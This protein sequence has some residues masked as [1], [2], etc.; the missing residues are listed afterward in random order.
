MFTSISWRYFTHLL[1][2]GVLTAILVSACKTTN[3]TSLTSYKQPVEDCRTVQHIMGSTCIPRNPQRVVTLDGLENTLALGI[4]PIA[5]TFVP[6]FPQ[7]KYLKGK[8]DQL[9]SVGDYNSPNIEKIL[10]LKPDLI[11]CSSRVEG[12]YKQL[13][14]I[15]PTVVLNMPYPPPSWKEQ[16][17]ELA[18]VLGKQEVSKQLMDE[19]WQ[20]IEK[21]QQALGV[22]AASPKQ[23][24]RE[25][26]KVSIANASSEYGI[27]SYV[28]WRKASF[29][30]SFEGYWSTTSQITK[31]IG[32][33]HV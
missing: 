32:R 13:S 27:W 4:R 3:D 19:Y 1:L 23:N 14:Y 28:L 15:A 22:D 8:L 6:G 20:R 30:L 2:L 11:V 26:M 7:P 5:S 10:R 25:T 12:I 24:R 31:K 21:L 16:L 17:E 29:W 33:A 9:E 18:K